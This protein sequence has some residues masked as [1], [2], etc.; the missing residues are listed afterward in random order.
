VR[1]TSG[2]CGRNSPVGRHGHSAHDGGRSLA[3]DGA[4]NFRFSVRVTTQ[5][6]SRPTLLDIDR[7]TARCALAQVLGEIGLP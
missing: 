7:G 2:S 6:G 3:R 5:A 4:R 1:G